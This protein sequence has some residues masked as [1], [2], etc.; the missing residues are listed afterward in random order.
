VGLRGAGRKA[1]LVLIC[2]SA[3]DTAAS[4]Q[5][6]P[7]S[8]AAFAANA[9]TGRWNGYWSVQTR[10]CGDARRR[11]EVAG[12]LG[13]AE[14]GSL[15]GS[16]QSVVVPESGI[17]VARQVVTGRIYPNLTVSLSTEMFAECGSR[18]RGEQRLEYSGRLTQKRNTWLLDMQATE[19][20]CSSANCVVTRK[21]DLTKQ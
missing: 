1:L 5:F 16:F 18:A 4:G 8:P 6:T 7:V 12:V 20:P 17:D 21:F 11:Y 19:I 13:I 10:G 15:T 2:A 9:I 14:D 3:F